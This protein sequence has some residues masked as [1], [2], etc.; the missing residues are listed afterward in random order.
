ML[1]SEQMLP[2]R[3]RNMRQM[4]DLLGAEDVV[5]AEIE[6]M[7]EDMY[8]RESM[9]H[10]EL[11]NEEWLE[12]RL[13]DLTGAETEVTGYADDLLVFIQMNVGELGGLD[14]RAVRRFLN[15]WLPAHLKYSLGYLSV[16]PLMLQEWF[17]I[18]WLDI[19]MSF[20]FW[21]IR[22]LN[23]EW[24]LDGSVNL[25]QRP[26]W[27]MA[28]G[29]IQAA[30]QLT[31]KERSVFSRMECSRRFSGAG[32]QHE[33]GLEVKTAV[34]LGDVWRTAGKETGTV[35]RIS[36]RET[37]ESESVT[38]KKDLWYLDGSVML[39]GS[40]IPDAEIREESL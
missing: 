5:L 33:P 3:I 8:R 18:S 40:R 1:N 26:G 7:I 14:L 10:E 13:H 25:G 4:K 21:Q 28:V 29:I 6:R 2:G 32:E 37:A 31:G 24:L 9:L 27:E 16:Y 36:E 20:S 15:Q 38:V 22:L 39:D 12:R 23:G 30:V 34:S 35:I 11:V 19:H 17:R